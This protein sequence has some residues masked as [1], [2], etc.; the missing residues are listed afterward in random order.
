MSIEIDILN[1]IIV[2]V[3]GVLI[4]LIKE[5]TKTN[6][7]LSNSIKGLSLNVAYCPYRIEN[8]DRTK[9]GLNLNP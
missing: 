6:K 1:L 2:P 8:E 5:L 7:D 3:L 4:W 9:K